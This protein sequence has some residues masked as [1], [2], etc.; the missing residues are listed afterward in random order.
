ML[1][2][3]T[4]PIVRCEDRSPSRPAALPNIYSL[5]YRPRYILLDV[6]VAFRRYH[7]MTFALRIGAALWGIGGEE[8]ILILLIIAVL[9]GPGIIALAIVLLILRRQRGKKD[10]PSLPTRPA[11]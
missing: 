9:A 11:P 7:N 1:V 4:R 6:E 3:R 8:I 2:T 10:V 5:S